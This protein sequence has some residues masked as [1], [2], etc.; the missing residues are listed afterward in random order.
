MPLNPW[1]TTVSITLFVDCIWNTWA[2]SRYSFYFFFVPV[3]FQLIH[4]LKS[5]LVCHFDHFHIIR[6]SWVHTYS[7]FYRVNISCFFFRGLCVA[8]CSCAFSSPF[9]CNIRETVPQFIVIYTG[10]SICV[11]FQCTVSETNPL[12]PPPPHTHMLYLC[13]NQI[14]FSIIMRISFICIDV[15]YI[16]ALAIEMFCLFSGIIFC[17]LFFLHIECFVAYYKH[18]PESDNSIFIK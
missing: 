10:N 13:L 5:L 15:P 7:S 1:C 9:S 2:S 3:A 4:S 8:F 6:I 16:L 11:E 17:C 12:P 14:S 18:R